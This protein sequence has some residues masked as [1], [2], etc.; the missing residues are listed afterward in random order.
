MCYR[1]FRTP[2]AIALSPGLLCGLAALQI[3]VPL[4]RQRWWRCQRYLVVR[5]PKLRIVLG[6]SA[7]TIVLG[8]PYRVLTV[9]R[10]T[11][12]DAERLRC[13]THAM[14]ESYNVTHQNMN[15]EQYASVV[16]RQPVSTCRTIPSGSHSTHRHVCV[17][18]QQSKCIIYIGPIMPLCTQVSASICTSVSEPVSW[19]T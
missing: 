1:T 18:H 6:M 7:E 8:P 9:H 13:S 15:V 2:A 5:V 11:W 19:V 12:K 10:P 4:P 14:F 17:T 3:D 16:G